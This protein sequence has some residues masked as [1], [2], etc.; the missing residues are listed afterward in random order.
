MREL[1]PY[2]TV[3]S[4]LTLTVLLFT[5]IGWWLDARWS[6]SPLVTGIGAGVGAVIGL[7]NMI[8]LLV[9]LSK[10]RTQHQREEQSAIPTEK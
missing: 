4:Q 9:S 6:T 1:A 7:A 10:T 5:A 2:M 8:R 3:G